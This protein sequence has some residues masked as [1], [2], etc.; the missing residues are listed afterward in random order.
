MLIKKTTEKYQILK[1]KSNNCA[2]TAEGEAGTTNP[3]NTVSML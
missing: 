1:I 2:M 3:F